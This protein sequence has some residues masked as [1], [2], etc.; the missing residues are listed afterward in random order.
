MS[1]SWTNTTKCC[2]TCANWAGPRK[3]VLNSYVETESP[4]VRGN[5]YAGSSGGATQAPAAMMGNGCPKYQKWA[6]LR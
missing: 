1:I 6:A 2:A 4:G 3:L 5:C